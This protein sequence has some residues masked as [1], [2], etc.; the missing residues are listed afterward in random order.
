MKKLI[1]IFGLAAL[2]FGGCSNPVENS[3]EPM[4]LE[5]NSLNKLS[6]EVIDNPLVLPTQL[7][8]SKEISGN[9]GGNIVLSGQ[10]KNAFGD[11]ISVDVKLTIPKGAFIG[12][13]NISIKTDKLNPCLEFQP[14]S[15][16]SKVLK[17]NLKFKGLSAD[18]YNLVS[19][20]TVFAHIADNGNVSP[21]LDEGLVV[22]KT[23]KLTSVNG[24]NIMHFSRY[25]FVRKS[26]K[27][28]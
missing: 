3:M 14:A 8:T 16:F 7:F 21:V 23:S 28:S 1:T 20:E 24:A 17:L 12:I 15:V 11:T 5:Q 6:V 9:N 19:G 22:D 18:R 4:K 13:K 26:P 2:L 25:G 27:Q 10:Y